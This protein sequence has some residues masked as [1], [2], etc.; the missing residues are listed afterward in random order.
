MMVI[1]KSQHRRPMGGHHYPEG[2]IVVRGDTVEQVAEKIKDLRINNGIPV[3]DPYRDIIDYYEKRFP[4]MLKHG[5]EVAKKELHPRYVRFR[6]WIQ[7]LWKNPP[8]RLITKKEASLRWDICKTCPKNWKKAWDKSEESQELE[9]RAYMMRYGQQVPE[10][11]GYCTCHRAD[12]PVLIYLD[13]PEEF[14]AKDKNEQA[15]KECWLNHSGQ[16]AR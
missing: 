14:S 13:K 7:A 4:F 1:N 15:P 6:H 8:K 5:E 10:F 11:L 9:R 2:A 16:V 12:L 3:G